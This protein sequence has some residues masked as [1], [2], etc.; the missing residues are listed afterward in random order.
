M[1]P[2]QQE[3]SETTWSFHHPLSYYS[4]CLY[5]N[6][7]V[8]LKIEEWISDKKSEGKRAAMENQSRKEIPLFLTILAKKT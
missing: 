2:S 5:E 6:G 7:F 3:R 1:N 4:K 8:I